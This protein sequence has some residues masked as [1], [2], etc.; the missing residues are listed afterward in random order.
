MERQHPKRGSGTLNVAAPF[1]IGGRKKLVTRLRHCACGGALVSCRPQTSTHVPA[2][3]KQ[4]MQDTWHAGKLVALHSAIFVMAA[5][6]FTH[7]ISP[8]LWLP[9]KLTA[10]PSVPI[11]CHGIT[12]SCHNIRAGCNEGQKEQ[13]HSV[14]CLASRHGGKTWQAHPGRTHA[15]TARQH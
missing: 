6:G 8:L 5:A 9:A 1:L 4:C 10:M 12:G 11:A 14:T 2:K 13:M 15:S 7:G 3:N